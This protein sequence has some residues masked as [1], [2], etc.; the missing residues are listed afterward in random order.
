MHL[1]LWHQE[2]V[3]RPLQAS[4]LQPLSKQEIRGKEWAEY[5]R[6]AERFADEGQGKVAC[7]MVD[8]VYDELEPGDLPVTNRFL[9]EPG[10]T[11]QRE[12]K[13]KE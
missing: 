12:V 4:G 7:M 1:C 10:S 11:R 5:L 6:D 9:H 8:S 3:K 13:E 2:Q